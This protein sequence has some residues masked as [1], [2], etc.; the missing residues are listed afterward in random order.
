MY[1]GGHFKKGI[2]FAFPQKTQL[3]SGAYLVICRN[4]RAFAGNYGADIPVL[5]DF[6]GRL[7]HSG[8]KLELCTAAGA[9]MGRS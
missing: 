1:P 9:V 8:E 4:T 7:S 3:P 6:S 5:G 2:V